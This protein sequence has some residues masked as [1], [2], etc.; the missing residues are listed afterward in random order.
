MATQAMLPN[1]ADC[2]WHT[3]RKNSLARHGILPAKHKVLVTLPG[4]GVKLGKWP[5]ALAHRRRGAHVAPFS[6]GSVMEPRV[7]SARLGDR[8]AESSGLTDHGW[9]PL[10]LGQYKLLAKLGEGGMGAVY[11]ALHTRLNRPV[12]I[13]LL[14]AS[15]MQDAEALARFEREMQ[16][17]GALDHVHIVRAMDAGEHN[18]THYLVMELV[19]GLD[20]GEVVRRL[21]PL[22]V[23]DACEIVRQAALGLQHAYENGLVH[24]DIKPSNLM[25]AAGPHGVQ[26]K[27]LDLGLALLDRATADG[28]L[29]NSDQIVGTIDYMAPEQAGSTHTVDIRADIYSLGAT[30]HKLL[31]RRVPFQ[32]PQYSTTVKKLVAL[33]T[34]APPPIDAL[35]PDLPPGLVQVVHCMLARLPDKRYATPW[36]LAQALAP[37]AEGADLAAL[38]AEA[39]EAQADPPVVDD[40]LGERWTPA[41]VAS[42]DTLAESVA[43]SAAELAPTATKPGKVAQPPWY[44]RKVTLAAA[45]AAVVLVASAAL[46]LR[47]SRDDI[48]VIERDIERNAD[49]AKPV[50]PDVPP[51]GPEPEVAAPEPAVAASEPVADTPAPPDGPWQPTTEQQAFFDQ[52]AKLPSDEQVTAVIDKLKEVNPGYDGEHR[53]H[54]LSG[55]MVELVIHSDQLRDIWPV[56]ALT[57][58]QSLRCGGK[59]HSQL[60]SLGPLAGLQLRRLFCTKTEIADLSPLR[61]MPLETLECAYT[62]VSDL[63]PLAGMP[64]TQLGITNCYRVKDLSP[65]QGMK[66]T[67]LFMARTAVADLSPLA[68]MPLQTLHL[69]ECRHITDLSPLR[70]MPLRHLSIDGCGQLTDFSFLD[71]M[72]LEVLDCN[73]TRFSDLAILGRM[74]LKNIEVERTDISDLT[75]LKDMDLRAV[76][77]FGAPIGDYSPLKGKPIVSMSITP[78]LYDDELDAVMRSLPLR[79]LWQ[80]GTHWPYMS[81]N[82]YWST[83]AEKRSAAEAFARQTEKLPADRRI[84]AVQKRLSDLNFAGRVQLNYS[85]VAGSITNIMLTLKSDE[86]WDISPVMALGKVRNVTIRGGHVTQDLSCLKFLGVEDLV[87]PEGMVFTNQ[88]TLRTIPTL[89]SINGT[90]ADEYIDKAR[91]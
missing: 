8:S 17:V 47:A 73:N 59:I 18:G 62:R 35:R 79:D 51:P 5:P 24:R 77:C 42:R 43:S 87:C 63:S 50:Q 14:P 83:L 58:L 4:Y 16:A 90:P 9:L 55:V 88:S 6:S 78:R 26:V 53:Y 86:S 40:S 52:V 12:A 71:G 75:P 20:V 67:R 85:L 27:I 44:A 31:T 46:F 1:S 21:G 13:K 45:A 19:Q 37:W 15:R 11:R 30:L 57:D 34:E 48:A 29:T 3:P 74:P 65:L 80:Q 81:I 72:L 64:L 60:G 68:G 49:A 66:L 33:A 23:A 32:G 84:G 36:E 41:V 7:Q 54:V 38:L 61:G 2:G 22:S 56:R 70:G 69:S 39:Q 82:E 25:L 28:Q 76:S 89:V 10:E 91:P